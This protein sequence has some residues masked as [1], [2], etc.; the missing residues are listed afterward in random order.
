LTGRGAGPGG[1][2]VSGP[3]TS[4][5][6]TARGPRRSDPARFDAVVLAGG[7]GR[8]LGGVDKPALRVGGHT[9]LDQAL[10]AVQGAGAG[11]VV[12]VG[13]E[14]DLPPDTGQAREQPPG[15]GPLA[16]LVAGL[17]HLASRGVP[18]GVVAVLAADL[19][20]VTSAHVTNLLDELE[21]AGPTVAAAV[22]IDGTG[23]WQPL[24]A[25]YRWRPLDHLLATAG[26][27]RDRP[28]RWL[29]ETLPALPV[30]L[31]SSATWDVDTTADL[32][33]L[34]LDDW[35]HRLCAA[36]GVDPD[37]VD[38]PAVLDLARDAA[39]NVA[40]PA[41]PLSTFVAGY[42]AGLAGGGADAVDTAVQH[43][44]ALARAEAD[45][46][47]GAGTATDAATGPGDGATDGSAAG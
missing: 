41:A 29:P 30:A 19:P 33:V 25:A 36:L 7:A 6:G 39:H 32:E 1:G 34:V 31:P 5:A 18:A 13:P 10:A 14:R 37:V 11:R 17:D 9:L 28:V 22:A 3:D 40:R 23:R 46:A 43:A 44:A 45:L 35:V 21:A 26:D 20:G 15:G 2:T 38:V 16:A 27:P 4:S 12:V 8:R 24:L 47:T 42:A